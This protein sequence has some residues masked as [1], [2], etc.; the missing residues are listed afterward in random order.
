MRV[1]DLDQLADSMYLI[2]CSFSGDYGYDNT[3]QINF[4]QA[5]DLAQHPLEGINA[6]Y[7]SLKITTILSNTGHN[8]NQTSSTGIDVSV[9][10]IP[11]LP[12]ICFQIVGFSKGFF[13][14]LAV[15]KQRV[16]GP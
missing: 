7:C 2:L 11:T 14:K 8:P 12:P 9:K 3:N 16:S 5:Q 6:S 10:R 15:P 13:C 1:Q 4:K